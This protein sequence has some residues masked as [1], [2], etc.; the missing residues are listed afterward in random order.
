MKNKN[1][2]ILDCTLRDGGYLIDW[3][4]GKNK[5]QSI[6]NNLAQGNIDF[7]ECGFLKE[8]LYDENKSFYSSISELEKLI[9]K[10]QNYTLMINF[11]EY[12]IKN[13][14]VCKN[15]NIKI[16][17]AFKKNNQKEALEY[18]FELKKLGWDVF[19]NPMSTNTYSEKEL[20]DL[21]TQLNQIKPFC[22]TIVDTLGNMYESDV[23][24]IF[25]FIDKFLDK[26][27]A[28]GFHSHNSMQLSFS[29]TK[30]LL[31]M[32]LDRIL[33]IDSC[34]YGMGRG[35]GNLCSELIIKYINDFYNSEYK[36]L[37]I[38]KSI[39]ED[40]KPIY[41]KSPW[42]YSTPYYIAAINGC[43]PNYAGFLVNKNYSDEEINRILSNIP[44]YKKT[45][46]DK[47][48]IED[49]AKKL[50]TSFSLV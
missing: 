39:D 8:D 48:L 43:H 49:L 47:D 37:P 33:I 38:L 5:I 6:I 46:Y 45:S 20:F 10:S 2:K 31:K 41:E 19:A 4:F 24:K 16:R 40:L 13:F 26:K 25:E 3:E 27:I 23:I 30:A 34:L 21:I 32:N 29:N 28:I 1:I 36:I 17:L 9:T 11:G 42:G 12:D 18:I 15:K 44:Q 7:I 22:M 35:A 14:S 50:F